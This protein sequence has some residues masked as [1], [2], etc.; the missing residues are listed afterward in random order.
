MSFLYSVRTAA[1][2]AALVVAAS[3]VPANA[4]SISL[5]MAVSATVIAGCLM[6]PAPL[7]FGNYDP[8][9]TN[10]TTA[11]TPIS[12][13]CTPGT[14]AKVTL[15]AGLNAGGS[16][17]FSS[18]SLKFLTSSLPYQIY[19]D[20]GHSTVWGDGVTGTTGAPTVTGTGLPSTLTAYG[21]IPAGSLVSPGVYLD[22]VAVTVTF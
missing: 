14:S 12:L 5:P 13:T 4:S 6:L 22:T 19:T 1:V 2:A 17:A 7:S 3:A 9:A 18:R 20:N 11:S 21:V 15:D 10:A 8:T 16:T